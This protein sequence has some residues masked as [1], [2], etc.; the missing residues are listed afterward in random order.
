ME[1]KSYVYKCPYLVV[2]LEMVDG[3]ERV[4]CVQSEVSLPPAVFPGAG[5]VTPVIVL[6][7]AAAMALLVLVFTTFRRLISVS[8][9][10]IG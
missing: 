6:H 2:S 1:K 7:V 9:P 4:L 5:E 8:L 3:A 10:N